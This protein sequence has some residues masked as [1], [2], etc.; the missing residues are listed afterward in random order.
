MKKIKRNVLIGGPMDPGDELDP[1]YKVMECSC[2]GKKIIMIRKQWDETRNPE[3]LVK[4]CLL[5]VYK[6]A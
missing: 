1:T 6:F 4:L 2:C 5:C 3:S